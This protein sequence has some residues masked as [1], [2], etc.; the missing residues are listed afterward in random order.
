MVRLSRAPARS[1]QT[2]DELRPSIREVSL[3]GSNKL[4][5]PSTGEPLAW[6]GRTYRVAVLDA[7]DYLHVR[8]TDESPR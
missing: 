8:P 2:S 7:G 6:A 3:L 4:G 1:T 5:R